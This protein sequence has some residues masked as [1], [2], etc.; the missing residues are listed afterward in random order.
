MNLDRR[1][2]RLEKTHG[3]YPRWKMPT[4]DVCEL[5]EE[6][7]ERQIREA[8]RAYAAAGCHFPESGPT[9][10]VVCRQQVPTPQS[11]AALVFRIEREDAPLGSAR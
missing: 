1:L 2:K 10:F 6:E 4:I 3:L 7:A 8:E 5:G 9:C 11:Q